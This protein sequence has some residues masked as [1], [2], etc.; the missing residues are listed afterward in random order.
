MHQHATSPHA[1]PAWLDPARVRDLFHSVRRGEVFDLGRRVTAASPR[2]PMQPP[3]TLTV[4]GMPISEMMGA[5]NPLD[6]YAEHAGMTFHVGTHIDALGHFA[7]NGKWFGGS[8]ASMAD[9]GGLASH[10][11][12]QIG[13]LISRAAV[14]DVASWRGTP[15]LDPSERITQSMLEQ[16]CAAQR[17]TVEPGDVVLIRTGWGRHYTGDGERY[18]ASE[19]GIDEEAARYLSRCGAIAVGA[20]NMA[21]EVLPFT[22][23]RRAFPVHQHFLAEAGVHIIENLA[24]DAICATG[25]RAGVFFLLPVKFVGATASP[26]TPILV[27]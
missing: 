21:L 25:I 9:E 7:A 10:G 19:P 8:E 22:E 15:C 26:A 4:Q 1:H 6:V 27:T 17:I 24:L 14:V 3:Y 23:R 16:A 5:D 2:L 18:V 13:P 12:E 11:I 20:D